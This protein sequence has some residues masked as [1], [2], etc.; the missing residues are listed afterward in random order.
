MIL[1]VP[2]PVYP[3]LT[4]INK[5]LLQEPAGKVW[6]VAAAVGPQTHLCRSTQLLDKRYCGS[7]NSWKQIESHVWVSPFKSMAELFRAENGRK[8]LSP[9]PQFPTYTDSLCWL[10]NVPGTTTVQRFEL[11][12]PLNDMTKCSIGSHYSWIH[13]GE[14]LPW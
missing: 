8:E 3:K 2:L 14:K 12:Q 4:L 11:C 10:E 1:F 7:A 9:W 6:C 5:R 13:L